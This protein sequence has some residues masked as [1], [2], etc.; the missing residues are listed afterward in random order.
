MENRERPMGGQEGSWPGEPSRT[1]TGAGG[2]GRGYGEPGRE[3]AEQAGRVADIAAARAK[4]FVSSA[5]EQAQQAAEY[6]QGAVDPIREKVAEYTDGGFEKMRDD[7]LTYT[8]QQP[9]NALMIAAGVGLILGWL[10]AMGG[11]R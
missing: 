5:R 9:M 4:G 3:M 10:T 11:R 2:A 6:V 7:A 1:T 8:R